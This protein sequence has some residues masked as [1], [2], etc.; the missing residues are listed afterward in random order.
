MVTN[1]APRLSICSFTAL[2]TSYPL[3]TAPK[4]RAVAMACNPGDAR[5]DDQHSRGS[6]GPGRSGHHGKHFR[7]RG[8]GEQDGFVSGDR[9]HGRQRVHR[10]RARGARHEFHGKQR[11]SRLPIARGEREI[12]QRIAKPDG[13]DVRLRRLLRHAHVQQH[14]GAIA[15]LVDQRQLR[16]LG[17]VIVVREAGFEAGAALHPHFHARFFQKVD[18]SR[19]GGNAA[20]GWEGFFEYTNS[21]CQL[22]KTILII[23]NAGAG[24]CRNS[25][26]C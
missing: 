8:G 16:A 11:D 7:Q 21:D 18:G 23:S 24:M 14:L 26:V 10:L 19:N 1:F 13:D 3:T 2:R 22:G 4:R 25:G 12:G 20:F 5:A 9:S 6:H 17:D 15:H